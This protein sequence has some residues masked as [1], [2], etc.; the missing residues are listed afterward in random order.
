VDQV[1]AAVR[2]TPAIARDF[3]DVKLS[4]LRVSKAVDTGKRTVRNSDPATFVVM[5]LPKNAGKSGAGGAGGAGG[6]VAE[7]EK[8]A[9]ARTE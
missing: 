3:P 1:L 9:Q 8:P 4:S 6:A 2:G 5:C 7:G